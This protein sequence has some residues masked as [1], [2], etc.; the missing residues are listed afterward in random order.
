MVQGEIPS[1]W[2]FTLW[3][4]MHIHWKWYM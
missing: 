1:C 2:L 3:N 4:E